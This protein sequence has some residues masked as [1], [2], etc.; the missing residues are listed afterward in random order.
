MRTETIK[1]GKLAQDL[2]SQAYGFLF[3]YK[4]PDVPF[5]KDNPMRFTPRKPFDVVGSFK[6]IPFAI[7][8]K[9]HKKLNLAWP[10]GCVSDN[11][12][13]SLKKYRMSGGVSLIG[14]FIQDQLYFISLSV[15]LNSKLSNKSIRFD[16]TSIGIKMYKYNN[17]WSLEAFE[18][19]LNSQYDNIDI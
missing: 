3:W 12:I 1:T 10:L 8:F 11:Q 18:I 19:I 9:H 6:G 15:F 14:L 16:K 17:K 2:K 7:E 13:T 4:I 5:I